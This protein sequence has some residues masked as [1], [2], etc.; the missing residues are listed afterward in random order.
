MTQAIPADSSGKTK[1][2]FDLGLQFAQD[3][4]I[5]IDANTL[6]DALAS[7]ASGVQAFFLGDADAGI[8]GLADS[9]NQRL[10]TL[11]ASNGQVQAESDAAKALIDS[12][13]QQIDAETTR[14]NKKYDLMTTQFIQLDQLYESDDLR[15]ELSHQSV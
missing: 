13:N 2:M 3:G 9:L 14:L 15:V 12:T 10:T 8:T 4:T 1:T 6:S 11:L 5:S 7:D